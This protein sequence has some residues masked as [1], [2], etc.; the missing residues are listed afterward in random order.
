MSKERVYFEHGVEYYIQ[1]DGDDPIKLA[2]STEPLSDEDAIDRS[3]LKME[4]G[5]WEG[6]E[7]RWKVGKK[8]F[9]IFSKQK[10]FQN[11]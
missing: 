3:T 4:V 9:K 6:S 11:L 7:L 10:D 5:P 8:K 1:F 2:E